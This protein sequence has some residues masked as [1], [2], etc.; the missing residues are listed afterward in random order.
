MAIETVKSN[1]KEAQRLLEEFVTDEKSW[2]AIEKAGNELVTAFQN[3][4]KIIACGNG[5]SMADAIHFTEEL[6]SNFRRKRK[7]LPALVV[8]DPGYLS[9]ASNDFGFEN[10]FSRYVDTMG[11]AGDVLFA[12]ST[13]GNSEN[14]LRAV[15]QAKQKGLRVVALTGKGGGKLSTLCDI[16]VRA[17]YSDF[18]DRTQEIHIKIIHSLIHYIELSMKL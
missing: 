17:P 1:F 2:I 13:S 5:G 3:G 7:G 15:N 6:T 14:I 4:K 10:V 9:C 16:E 11:Q 12:I 8:S 18:S